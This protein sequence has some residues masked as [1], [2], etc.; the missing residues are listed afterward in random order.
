M[1]NE[2]R[3]IEIVEIDEM[4]HFRVKKNEN[5]GSGLRSTGWTRNSLPTPLAVAVRKPGKDYLAYSTAIALF[6]WQQMDSRCTNKLS[7]WNIL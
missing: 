1:P 2:I 7:L 4:W 5:Y 6:K 3:D